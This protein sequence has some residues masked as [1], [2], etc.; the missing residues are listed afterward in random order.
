MKVRKI[1]LIITFILILIITKKTLAVEYYEIDNKNRYD[2]IEKAFSEWMESFKSDDME[3]SKKIIDYKMGGMGTIESNKNKIRAYIEFT[4]TP[5]SKENTK[6]NYTEDKEKRIIDGREIY[7]VQNDNICFIEMTNLS[8]EYKVDYISQ[9]PKGYD[10][11]LEKFEEYKA[12]LPKTQ[13]TKKVQG[14]IEQNNLANEQIEK[15]SNKIFVICSFVLVLTIICM[16][17]IRKK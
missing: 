10:E 13:D 11:F 3:E 2:I 7:I 12:N 17:V 16:M 4:V 8:G 9:T 5:F 1:L 6:W 14:R 15:M